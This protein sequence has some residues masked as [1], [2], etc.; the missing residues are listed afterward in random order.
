MSRKIISIIIIFLMFFCKK[1]YG[2]DE[3]YNYKNDKTGYSVIIED[4]ANLLTENEK[5]DLKNVMIDL[6]EYGNI[7]FK[8]IDENN[9]YSTA[10]FAENYYIN[11]CG[12]QNG[13]VFVID[14]DYRKIYIYSRGNSFNVITTAKAETITDNTYKYAS[15]KEYYECARETYMQI[16]SVFRG[17]KI[18]EPMKYISNSLIS[19]MLALLI[20]FLIFVFAA[21]TKKAKEKELIKE[22]GGFFE[23]TTPEVV[24]T[25]THR[26]YSPIS[27]GDGGSSRRSV[28]AGGRW[29]VVGGGR[30]P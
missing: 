3:E 7:L 10:G 30:W 23:H 20:N 16:Y 19:I 28:V 2:V 27:D 8:T 26:E 5:K 6:T 17:E 22:C 12:N 21:K 9:S 25:G 24:H 1:C 29:S 14:M 11:T 18:A 4:D 15:R 13:T